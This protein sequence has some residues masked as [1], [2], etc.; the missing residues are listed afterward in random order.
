MADFSRIERQV[1]G[2][3]ARRRFADRAVS[4]VPWSIARTL[5]RRYDEEWTA[6]R[7]AGHGLV[8]AHQLASSFL[9]G[10]VASLGPVLSIY[11]LERSEGLLNHIGAIDLVQPGQRVKDGPVDT[12][13]EPT[14]LFRN[15][16]GERVVFAVF[17]RDKESGEQRYDRLDTNPFRTG[18]NVFSRTSK[19]AA[20]SFSLPAGTPHGGGTCAAAALVTDPN[21]TGICPICYATGGSF[22][23][24]PA[25][26][27]AALRML[28]VERTL[29]EDPSSKRFSTYLRTSIEAYARN[30][31]DPGHEIGTWTGDALKSGSRPRHLTTFSPKSLPTPGPV[32]TDRFEVWSDSP[33]R[34]RSPDQ[35]LVRVKKK[36]R[37][38][39]DL[40]YPLGSVGDC[41]T[42]E[43]QVQ[44]QGKPK[45]VTLPF[46]T[47]AQVFESR[48]VEVNEVAGYFRIHDAGDVTIGTK[49]EHRPALAAAYQRAWRLVALAL[50]QVLF[51][52][53]TRAW[54]L[55]TAYHELYAELAASSELPNLIVRPSSLT[56]DGAAPLVAWD[57]KTWR[58][59]D[60][61]KARKVPLHLDAGSTANFHTH[62]V[63][64]DLG[65]F[66]YVTDSLGNPAFQCP[67]NYALLREDQTP[68]KITAYMKKEDVGEEVAK[69]ELKG[70]LFKAADCQ[71]A[72]CRWCWVKRASPVSYGQH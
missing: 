8:E 26:L 48:G 13:K 50:P 53:P 27:T 67:V 17:A 20:P 63:K 15:R 44:V 70:R 42:W 51:W 25:T 66:V 19:M 56:V 29:L 2:P 34:R 59:V 45:R 33:T 37:P 5:E 39:N 23:Y 36:K 21:R 60:P 30:G 72:G 6:A 69:K 47:S 55:S 49:M 7:R 31:S 52:E 16:A 38:A 35:K 4:L 71:E 54:G 10:P 18:V 11:G 58:R 43:R 32:V 57:P 64:G 41:E 68:A 22:M 46:A 62:D 9:A 40:R 3:L 65:A 61:A 28:W 24:G 1:G 12:V 14:L